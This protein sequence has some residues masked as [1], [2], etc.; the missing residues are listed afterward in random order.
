M[1]ARKHDTLRSASSPARRHSPAAAPALPPRPAPS[2][3][4][5]FDVGWIVTL[6]SATVVGTD[7]GTT[8]ALATAVYADPDD[9]GWMAA[10]PGREPVL[11]GEDHR[12]R[13]TSGLDGM[14][15]L[16]DES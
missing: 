5:A 15:S 12:V 8:D 6:H 3:V 16:E 14:I 7:L 4:R 1:T 2:P 10:F 13:W 9:L 11:I